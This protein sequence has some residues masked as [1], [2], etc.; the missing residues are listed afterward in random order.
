MIFH[1]LGESLC[2]RL[3]QDGINVANFHRHEKRPLQTGDGCVRK[4]RVRPAGVVVGVTEQVEDGAFVSLRMGWILVSWLCLVLSLSLRLR[5][6]P[7]ISVRNI[8]FSRV[9]GGCSLGEIQR[10]V[11]A[12]I[13]TNV[14][15]EDV[16]AIWVEAGSS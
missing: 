1:N 3:V 11:K 4:D 10:P 13:A 8:R 6:S 12:V 5:M 15:E 14:T 16:E 7:L 9:D 2:Q